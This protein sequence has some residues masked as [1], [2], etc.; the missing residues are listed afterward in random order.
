MPAAE[1]IA[2]GTE[3][4]LGESQ[5]T[6]T[7]F[8]ARQLR[9]IG[10]DIYR[11]TIVGDNL[12]RIEQII[13]EARTRT[14][15]II[16]TGGLGP[17]V[18]DPTRQAVAAAFDVELQFRPDQWKNIEAHFRRMNWSPSENNKRQ[19][20]IP[21]GAT[22]ID[23]PVGTA[24]AFACISDE[25]VVISLPG[26]PREME[27]LI[28]TH[29]IPFLKEHFN[30][31]GTIKARVLHTSGIGESQ[32]DALVDDLETLSNPTVGLLAHPG[33]T[34]IRITA[35]ADTLLEADRMIRKV[36]KKVRERLGDH[37]F[38]AD[39][40]TLEGTI[41]Q[42]L[43]TYQLT[44]VTLEHGL[45]NSLAE[46][47]QSVGIAPENTQTVLSTDIHDTLDKLRA[48]RNAQYGLV[49]MVQ[50]GEH[51]TLLTLTLLTPEQ[52]LNQTRKYLGESSLAAKWAVNSA[53]DML[54]RE[55]LKLG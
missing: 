26:V 49:V 43:I 48:E 5:D 37:I 21:A 11:T 15:I 51:G 47:L 12:N 13:R 30:L 41:A 16:T 45:N 53:L 18:D 24:P 36:E 52:E 32:V 28:K 31:Q 39:Q 10:V 22:P 9:D 8:I 17:T 34:D 2:I 44:L 14:N 27:L 42:L 23:N 50:P 55:L 40:D 4:L 7:R 25:Q 38:G 1:I 3:L 54:R 6:N 19:A 35:K 20:Y 33:N 29:V 46:C